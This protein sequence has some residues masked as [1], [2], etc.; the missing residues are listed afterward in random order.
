MTLTLGYGLDTHNRTIFHRVN[1]SQIRFFLFFH[2]V[3]FLQIRKSLSCFK[4]F[5]LADPLQARVAFLSLKPPSLPTLLWGRN[6][7]TTGCSLYRLVSKPHPLVS[8][9]AQRTTSLGLLV[10]RLV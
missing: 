1:F 10:L 9:D 4:A 6:L 8:L 3:N 7:L 2:R 5:L